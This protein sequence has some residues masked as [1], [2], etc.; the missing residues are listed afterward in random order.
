MMDATV[1]SVLRLWSQGTS[2]K[3]IARRLRI[4]DQKVCKILVTTGEIETDE[5]KLLMSGLSVNQ[6]AEKLNKSVKSVIARIPYKKGVYNAEYPT[7]NAIRIR[8][9]R[10][11]K[12]KS[13]E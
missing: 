4:S 5:S 6:I 3:E 1:Q 9:T 8:K 7:I 11:R 12:E 10:Q 13:D 2:Q